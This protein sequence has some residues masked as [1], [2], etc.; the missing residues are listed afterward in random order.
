MQKIT[1]GYAQASEQV[2]FH[3]AV[4]GSLEAAVNAHPEIELVVL[5]NEMDTER[6]MKNT[7]TLAEI[8][9]DVAIICHVDERTASQVIKPLQDKFIPV[10]A[11]EVPMPVVTYF[12][13]NNEKAGQ[14]LGGALAEWVQDNWGGNVDKVLAMTD[15][16]FTS[17]I[18]SRMENAVEALTQAGV[19]SK[20]HVLYLQSDSNYEGAK[21]YAQT[22]LS[23]WGTDTRVVVVGAN[24]D[25]AM[26]ALDVATELGFGGNVVGGGFGGTRLVDREFAN[27]NSPFIAS[28]EF[29]PEN[30]GEPLL[31]L[32]LQ[33]VHKERVKPNNFVE[34]SC[35]KR[36]G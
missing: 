22:S 8:G 35:R 12:G 3:Q 7:Q 15:Y 14:L 21:H 4:L 19:V 25:A 29:H 26:G 34:P 18:R 6:A 20:D 32:A 17:F 5:N 33:M 31:A 16:R 10:I 30:Y 27:E 11:L 9:V 28:I 2:S 13:I 23:N 24:D 36:W 1:V